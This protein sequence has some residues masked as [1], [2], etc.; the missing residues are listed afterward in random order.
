[1]KAG[2]IVGGLLLIVAVLT[3]I[4]TRAT[5]KKEPYRGALD[6]LAKAREAKE[7]NSL[8]KKSEN[9]PIQEGEKATDKEI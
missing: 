6:N 4:L 3:V 7:F 9:E 1:M 5:G 2:Y 8:L